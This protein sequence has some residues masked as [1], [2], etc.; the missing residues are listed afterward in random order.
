METSQSFSKWHLDVY[1]YAVK[2]GLVVHN[3]DYTLKQ[4]IEIADQYEED[5]RSDL[6]E[7]SMMES[8]RKIQIENEGRGSEWKESEEYFKLLDKLQGVKACAF[9]KL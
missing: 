8:S 6:L 2:S 7:L 9:C 4:I 3:D 5:H 1:I